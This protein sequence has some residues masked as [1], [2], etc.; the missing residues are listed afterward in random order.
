MNI[1]HV[2]VTHTTDTHIEVQVMLQTFIYELA[3]MLP[4]ISNVVIDGCFPGQLTKVSL[5]HP[6]PSTLCHYRGKR[7]PISILDSRTP[8]PSLATR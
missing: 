2:Y 8:P 1:Y 7:R 5:A 3:F 4:H 6:I